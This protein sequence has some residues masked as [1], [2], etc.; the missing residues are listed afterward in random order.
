M[1]LQKRTCFITTK[2]TGLKPID[3][4]NGAQQWVN[5]TVLITINDLRGDF[6]NGDVTASAATLLHELGHAYYDLSSFLGGSR[7]LPDGGEVNKSQNNQRLIKKD[8]F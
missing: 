3:I 7:I 8:C 5:G 1:N 4:G 2:V 6:V